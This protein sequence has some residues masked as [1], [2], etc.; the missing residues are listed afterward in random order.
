MIL[1]GMI[2]A[3]ARM[4]RYEQ[5]RRLQLQMARDRAMREK[6]EAALMED[7]EPSPPSRIPASKK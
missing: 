1:G 6:Y 7:D 3:D 4:H 2:E 5:Q